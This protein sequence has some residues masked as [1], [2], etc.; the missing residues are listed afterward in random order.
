LLK[1]GLRLKRDP[2]FL[3]IRERENNKRIGA[4]KVLGK[5]SKPP[6]TRKTLKE[7]IQIMADKRLLELFK[8]DPSLLDRYIEKLIG[9]EIPSESEMELSQLIERVRLRAYREISED[10]ELDPEI[11][12]ELRDRFVDQLLGHPAYPPRA[13]SASAHPPVPNLRNQF[14][15]IK[16]NIGYMKELKEVLGV[17]ENN[18]L[19]QLLDPEVIK[20]GLGLFQSTRGP[21]GLLSQPDNAADDKR[22]YVEIIDG[23]PLEMDFKTWMQYQQHKKLESNKPNSPNADQDTLANKPSVAND[24]L[25]NKDSNEDKLNKS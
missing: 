6:R 17:N 25:V 5:K 16:Q 8:K 2:L 15:R 14:E 20:A 12:E 10:A 1:R 3:F 18:W 4:I 21:S 11:K 7:K 22:I 13:R 23:K 24:N 19:K 9:I